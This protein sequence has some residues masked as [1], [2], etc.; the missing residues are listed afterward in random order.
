MEIRE[1]VHSNYITLIPVGELDANSSV[2]LDDRITTLLEAGTANIHIDGS[3]ISYISSPGLGVFVSYVD[4]LEIQGGRFVISSLAE[5]VADVFSLLG[6]DRLDRIIIVSDPNE[7]E[8][9]FSAS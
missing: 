7:V 5:N 4:E 8:S 2:H 6:L 1:I 9:H 3:N